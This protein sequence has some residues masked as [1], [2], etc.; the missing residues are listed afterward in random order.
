MPLTFVQPIGNAVV[1]HSGHRIVRNPMHGRTADLLPVIDIVALDPDQCV[2][3][4]RK[5]CVVQVWPFIL[6]RTVAQLDALAVGD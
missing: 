3:S 2:S 6:V 5:S 4:W 1:H